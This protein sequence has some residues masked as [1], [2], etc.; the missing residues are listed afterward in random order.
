M[1]VPDA[2]EALIT[3]RTK[4]A[5]VVDLYG[6]MPDW[7]KL[8]E[9][10]SRKGVALIED[11]AEAIGSHW[12][13]RPAGAFGVMATFSFHGSKT[14]TTGEGG[15][16]VLDDDALLARV[17]QLRDHGRSPGDTMF[18]NAEVGWKY[19][20]SSMQA[21]LGLAQ[22]ER[23]EELVAKK[24]EIFSWYREELGNWNYGHLNQ[25]VA[26]LFNSYW[27]ST[28]VLEPSFNLPKAVLIPR[29]KE[30]MID[31]RPFFHPLSSLP[32]FRG[33]PEAVVAKKRNSI[34]YKVTP[35]G[36][37][38]PSALNLDRGAVRHVCDVLRTLVQSMA[39]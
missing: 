21:A 28:L 11:A 39:V 31:V 25:D 32:A 20:M 18:F 30:K 16:L 17:L 15:M 26:G 27:M 4:A 12:Y 33:C 5:I 38:L 9:I 22:L 34:S 2:F 6:S 19:K 37:N 36:I 7:D 23:I 3:P 14:L 10:A 35:Y 24:R 1:Y 13:E 8:S 29:L